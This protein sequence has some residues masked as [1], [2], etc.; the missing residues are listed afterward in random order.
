MQAPDGKGALGGGDGVA[1]VRGEAG[2]GD[3]LLLIIALTPAPALLALFQ[4]PHHSALT[5]AGDERE[6]AGTGEIRAQQPLVGEVDLLAGKLRMKNSGA[7][8]N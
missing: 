6:L 4:I 5:Q 3:E 2:E 1:V 7:Q 8:L